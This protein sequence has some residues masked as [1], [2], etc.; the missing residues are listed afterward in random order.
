MQQQLATTPPA[1]Q[2]THSVAANVVYWQE[3]TKALTHH[4][5]PVLDRDRQNLYRAIR[6]GL[7]L[8]DTWQETAVL[9]LQ[10]FP[11]IEKRGYWGEWI[12]I[13]ERALD[14]CPADQLL[15][16]GR[17]LDCLGVFYRYNQQ[18]NKAYAA[19]QEEL[20]IGEASQDNW[21]IAH[22]SINLA[23]V[24]RHMRR[25]DEAEKHLSSAEIAFRASNAPLVK[26]AFVKLERGLLAQAQEQWSAAETH[27][28]DS[29]SLWREIGD[30]VNLANSLKLLGQVFVVLN[31]TE[32]ALKAY[33]EALDNLNPSENYLDQ[34]KILNDLAVLHFNQGNL[35]D[36]LYQLLA[37]NSSYLRQ[38]G[39]V[40]DQAMVSTNLG[41]V[42]Q[43]QGKLIEAERAFRRS[44]T[45]WETCGD[46]LQLV[47]AL[48]GLAEIKRAQ[49]DMIEAQKLGQDGLELLAD[50]PGDVWAQ[51]MQ[52]RLCEVATA[53]K[54][55]AIS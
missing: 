23:A 4:N 47:N 9:I 30:P 10:S 28:H 15:L 34:S 44:V 42:Y 8:A 43:A 11:L 33:Q 52:K 55:A 19:H 49:G 16:R 18:S 35:D 48:S 29:V 20:Q 7:Q 41:N 31:K 54:A 46:Q 51:K 6:F 12:P 40:F 50:Y 3:R 25:F 26:H 24:C 5:L 39:N 45:L 14:K 38:S 32:D 21:R 1:M 37:A 53:S 22:A 13:L 17:I 27:L 2:F 36:A